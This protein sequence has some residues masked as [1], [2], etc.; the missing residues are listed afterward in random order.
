MLQPITV[1]VVDCGKQ[2]TQHVIL[3]SELMNRI[4]FGRRMDPPWQNLLH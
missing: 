3:V 2:V 4:G 1:F